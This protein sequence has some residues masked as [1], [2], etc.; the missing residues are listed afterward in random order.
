MWEKGREGNRS[1][2]KGPRQKVLAAL[3]Q[4]RGHL[5]HTFI[6]WCPVLLSVPPVSAE[7]GPDRLIRERWPRDPTEL[8]RKGWYTGR[9]AF[10]CLCVGKGLP[11]I[12][13]CDRREHFLFQPGSRAVIKQSGQSAH[14]HLPQDPLRKPSCSCTRVYVKPE[15]SKSTA[16][17]KSNNEARET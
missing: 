5:Q 8:D 9:Q 11:S 14:T 1:W 15:L 12:S 10:G 17:W 13:C 3:S 4:G 7:V 16:A 6:G 2:W